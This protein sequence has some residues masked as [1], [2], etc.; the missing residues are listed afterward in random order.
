MFFVFGFGRFPRPSRFPSQKR[1]FVMRTGGKEL[2][3]F[4]AFFNSSSISSGSSGFD[5][6][7]G[8]GEVD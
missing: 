8:G 5:G 2:D 1:V 4:V 3:I 6:D 7:C